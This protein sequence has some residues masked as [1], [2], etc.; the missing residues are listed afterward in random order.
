MLSGNHFVIL[1]LQKNLCNSFAGVEILLRF[2]HQDDREGWFSNVLDDRECVVLCLS[3]PCHSE[4]SSAWAVSGI[5]G[6]AES[7]IFACFTG[8]L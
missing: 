8:L 5:L 7:F 6:N 3:R 4:H 1:Y 2:A